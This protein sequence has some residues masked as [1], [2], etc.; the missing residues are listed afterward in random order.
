MTSSPVSPQGYKTTKNQK[1]AIAAI[2][3]VVVAIFFT[4][5]ISIS[6]GMEARYDGTAVIV[7]HEIRGQK[8]VARI[9]RGDGVEIKQQAM[10]YRN[11]CG[12]IDDGDTVD[13]KDGVIYPRR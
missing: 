11:E 1:I 13:I 2:F 3:S 9:Q 4:A 5:A 6:R 7:S 12:R 10:G 8:C